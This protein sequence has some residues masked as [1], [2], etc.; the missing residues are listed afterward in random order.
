[1]TIAFGAAEGVN[2][3]EKAFDQVLGY[4]H[5]SIAR[6]AVCEAFM[7]IAPTSEVDDELCNDPVAAIDVTLEVCA[8]LGEEGE[9][10][11]GVEDC[12]STRHSSWYADQ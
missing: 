5:R 12:W 11:Q 6:Q 7:I 2:G 1:M 3:G 4:V 8:E 9:V 10:L